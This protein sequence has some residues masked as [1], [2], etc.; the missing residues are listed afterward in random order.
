MVQKF[1][2][3][4][5]DFKARLVNEIN[6]STDTKLISLLFM[7]G[8]RRENSIKQLQGAKKLCCVNSKLFSGLQLFS[9]T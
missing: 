3:F 1:L 9:V 5:T 7:G 2:V 6:S 8:S 4:S